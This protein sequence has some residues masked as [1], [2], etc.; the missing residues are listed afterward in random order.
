MESSITINQFN[1]S[2]STNRSPIRV[3]LRRLQRVFQLG[4]QRHSTLDM[5]VTDDD[6]DGNRRRCVFLSNFFVEAT[7]LH[8]GFLR[9]SFQSC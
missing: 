1:H 2:I 9:V 4:R 6:G 8:Y 7:T 3:R 5:S